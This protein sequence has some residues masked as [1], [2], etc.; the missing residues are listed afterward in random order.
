MAKARQAVVKFC[1]STLAPACRFL[2]SSCRTLKR[3]HDGSGDGEQA[4]LKFWQLPSCLLSFRG[5]IFSYHQRVYDG[6]VTCA[7]KEVRKLWFT[8][9]LFARCFLTRSTLMN[10][11]RWEFHSVLGD[12]VCSF[13]LRV[14]TGV[15]NNTLSLGF[16]LHLDTIV[17]SGVTFDSSCISKFVM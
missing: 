10:V 17:W 12:C 6:I 15:W 2:P 1:F 3:F 8:A 13:L 11:T 14:T 7:K 9:A 4:C 16:L 5:C